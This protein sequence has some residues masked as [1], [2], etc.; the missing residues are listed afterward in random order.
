MAEYLISKNEINI[1]NE[2]NDGK[3]ALNYILNDSPT[4]TSDN[5][6]TNIAYLLIKNGAIIDD[7]VM[8]NKI[9]QKVTKRLFKEAIKNND[10][11]LVKSLLAQKAHHVPNNFN[12]FVGYSGLGEYAQKKSKDKDIISI[13]EDALQKERE[14]NSLVEQ[15]LQ[16]PGSDKKLPKI[17]LNLDPYTTIVSSQKLPNN[18]KNNKSIGLKQ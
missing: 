9:I 10:T 1:N 8:D 3:T 6:K 15:K 14:P 7:K 4:S 18:I 5:K 2:N 17:K 16:N 11:K 13:I 12:S